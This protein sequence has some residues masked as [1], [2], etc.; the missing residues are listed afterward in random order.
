MAKQLIDIVPIIEFQKNREFSGSMTLQPHWGGFIAIKLF[1]LD[2]IIYNE[3]LC[4][5]TT[6]GF[7]LFI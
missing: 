1:I 3:K 5:Q 7:E 4:E 2:G 6:L